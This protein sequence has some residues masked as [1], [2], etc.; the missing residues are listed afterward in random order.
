MQIA[1]FGVDQIGMAVVFRPI[2]KGDPLAIRR[3]SG[4]ACVTA[5]GGQL[6]WITAIRVALPDLTSSCA[7]RPKYDLASIK[8]ELCCVIC[9]LSSNNSVLRNNLAACSGKIGAPY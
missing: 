6:R 2:V 4:C 7:L 9:A 8:R 1:A 3:P 5:E